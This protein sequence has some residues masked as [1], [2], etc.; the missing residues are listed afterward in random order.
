MS[1]EYTKLF[2]KEIPADI[3]DMKA[4]IAELNQKKY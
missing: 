1:T 2:T 3:N 4:K